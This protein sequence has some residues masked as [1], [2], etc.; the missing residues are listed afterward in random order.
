MKK[1]L[2][3]L[4]AAAA[5]LLPAAVRAQ[6][7]GQLSMKLDKKYYDATIGELELKVDNATA[8][9]Y[10][11]RAGFR[12]ERLTAG[13]WYPAEK[14]PDAP[15]EV[16]NTIPLPAGTSYATG[17]QMGGFQQPFAPGTYRITKS[18]LP[19][20]QTGD[21]VE[22]R[23]YFQ[24]M[25]PTLNLRTS[26]AESLLVR[27][28]GEEQEFLLDDYSGEA[29]PFYKIMQELR[30]FQAVDPPDE[31]T[32]SQANASVTLKTRN[33]DRWEITLYQGPFA[34]YAKTAESWYI[35]PDLE[36]IPRLRIH[37]ASYGGDS[38]AIGEDLINSL[39]ACP[40]MRNLEFTRH[41]FSTP[42]AYPGWRAAV[43]QEGEQLAIFRFPSAAKAKEQLRHVSTAASAASP[44]AY[45]VGLPDKKGGY[46]DV[47]TYK[48]TY[49][50]HYYRFGPLVVLYNGDDETIRDALQKAL[51]QEA[52]GAA[53]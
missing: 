7:A 35:A 21:P 37:T 13:V 9:S 29:S 27:M 5:F 17:L 23:E 50:P 25:D 24:V 1:I 41:T 16:W 14:I 32:L 22:L 18:F 39:V 15:G 49:P 46:T 12:L 43:S 40:S 36:M 3:L 19:S 2:A 10:E 44:D 34:T 28:P 6:E 47:K 26:G 11:G 31:K 4:L 33:D 52:A 38:R 20:G 42:F 53:L 48:W 45:S 30:R 51:G 8:H